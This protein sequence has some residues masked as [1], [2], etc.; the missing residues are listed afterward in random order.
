MTPTEDGEEPKSEQSIR[1][2]RSPLV[3]EVN[4]AREQVSDTSS[5]KVARN[6]A[7]V[8]MPNGFL[9]KARLERFRFGL[10]RGGVSASG[11]GGFDLASQMDRIDGH[12]FVDGFAHVVESEGGHCDCGKG[13]HFHSGRG[14]DS[15]CSGDDDPVSGF[16]K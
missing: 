13:L 3:L 6:C 5:R 10:N 7:A 15:A 16:R 9:S 14:D 1:R 11:Y 4:L 8:R 2:D 12:G